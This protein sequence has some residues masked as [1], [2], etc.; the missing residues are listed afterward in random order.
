M[1]GESKEI[2]G[3]QTE[4]DSTRPSGQ[5]ETIPIKTHF[6]LSDRLKNLFKRPVEAPSPEEIVERS[7]NEN[8][9]T[10]EAG[11]QLKDDILSGSK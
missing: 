11:K 3:A 7:V 5:P 4:A 8:Q 2:P 6:K 10:A 9:L 1:E